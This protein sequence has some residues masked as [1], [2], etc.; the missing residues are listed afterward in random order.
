MMNLLDWPP[1][2]ST[3]GLR[4]DNWIDSVD[5]ATVAVAAILVAATYF[6]RGPV[7]RKLIDWFEKLIDDVVGQIGERTKARLAKA[8]G[9][10]LMT[11][12]V[13]LAM[14]TL[15]LP[16]LA[17]GVARNILASVAI[18]AV[19]STW[20]ELCGPFVSVLRS[21]EFRD[22]ALES[23][24]VTR[25]TQFAILILGVTALLKVWEI[26]IS[27]ALTGVGVLGAGLAIAAQDLI[28]NL[29]A[30]MTNQSEKRFLTG[31]AIEIEGGLAGTVRRIDLRS[32]LVLGFDQVP[33]YVP[34]ADLSN[35]IVKNYS[36][37]QHRRVLLTVPLVLSS[38]DE[39]VTSV[40]SAIAAYLR[41][42]GDFDAGQADSFFARV[43][44]LG[45]S[46]IDIMVFALTPTGNYGEWLEITERLLLAIRRY[47]AEAG[48]E[49]AYPTRTVVLHNPADP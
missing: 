6:V 3:L 26:D 2:F 11:L 41:D 1:P 23:D 4:I 36:R 17:G 12:A 10:L 28:R 19:F 37:M 34:N 33:R 31:D 45:D 22:M 9:T 39:Q 38:T 14:E 47:I 42:S 43:S 18:V 16:P 15:E 48:T 35:A 7:A 44:A 27:G 40:Q 13:Y 24:W 8:V 32:T 29:I 21:G 20:Y 30:G 49:L 46:S 25:V 5:P